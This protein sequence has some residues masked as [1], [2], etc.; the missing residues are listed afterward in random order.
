MKPHTVLLLCVLLGCALLCILADPSRDVINQDTTNLL[1]DSDIDKSASSFDQA[2]FLSDREE[3]HETTSLQHRMPAGSEAISEIQAV[4]EAKVGATRRASGTAQRPKIC[5]NCGQLAWDLVPWSY[6]TKEHQAIVQQK[7]IAQAM[8]AF[9][10]LRPCCRCDDQR[11]FLGKLS[12]FERNLGRVL[13]KEVWEYAQRLDLRECVKKKIGRACKKQSEG[14]NLRRG[15]VHILSGVR[16][17]GGGLGAAAAV[18]AADDVSA[19]TQLTA[20]LKDSDDE[21]VGWDCG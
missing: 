10:E 5:L 6:I 7:I 15:P 11:S 9:G 19:D 12:S 4:A 18:A 17:R 3:Q 8:E 20:L 13:G 14:D 2:S 1:H 16:G 21:A